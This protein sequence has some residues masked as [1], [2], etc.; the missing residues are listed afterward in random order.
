MEIVCAVAATVHGASWIHSSMTMRAG[1]LVLIVEN[2]IP[3]WQS[4]IHSHQDVVVVDFI[5]YV[6]NAAVV[7]PPRQRMA[8]GQLVVAKAVAVTASH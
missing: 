4:Y 1:C 7:G 2:C 3:T 8:V 5:E 6:I